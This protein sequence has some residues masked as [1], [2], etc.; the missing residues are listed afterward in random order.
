MLKACIFSKFQAKVENLITSLHSWQNHHW[1]RIILH[2]MKTW[3]KAVI[4]Q[5]MGVR[6]LPGH[7]QS[8]GFYPSSFLMRENTIFK[9][10]LPLQ[11]RKHKAVDNHHCHLKGELYFFWS[12]VMSPGSTLTLSDTIWNSWKTSD[13]KILGQ[14]CCQGSKYSSEE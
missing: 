6:S 10:S 3:F 12:K 7:Q 9:W 13:N 11:C 1:Q 4:V 8:W 14:K 5:N 2:A